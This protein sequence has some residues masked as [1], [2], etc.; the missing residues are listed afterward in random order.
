MNVLLKTAA[1]SLA[2]VLVSACLHGCGS[3]EA[4]P[5]ASIPSASPPPA[6]SEPVDPPVSQPAA[7]TSEFVLPAE[8]EPLPA[9]TPPE[10]IMETT[11]GQVRLR[12]NGRETPETVDNFLDR[13]VDRG[14][15]A[16]VIF[17]HVDSGV[18]V[19]GGYTEDL[20][21]IESLAPIRNE[22]A[23]GSKN[24]RG[25]IAMVR[26]AEY[27]DSATSQF[28]FNLVDDPTLDY[29]EASGNAGYCVFGE[30][31]E[32][33][34]VLDS[35]SKVEVQERD[36]FPSIPVTAVIIKSIKRVLP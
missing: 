3:G 9:Y 12:L 13:Y 7:L 18:V 28:F 22:A 5:T 10:V 8:T 14:V 31:T 35:I 19:T 20:T 24:R 36:G 29:D 23:N 2:V 27:P 34:D 32:G 11:L 16:G 6:S 4:P 26:S 17:H 30:V 1:F 15:Y 25:T 21:P 33:L